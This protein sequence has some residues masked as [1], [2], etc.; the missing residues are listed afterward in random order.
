LL[1]FILHCSI[2]IS[3]FLLRAPRPSLPSPEPNTK[4]PAVPS[5]I[6]S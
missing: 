2:S 3:R 5:S 6:R 1:F 4:P